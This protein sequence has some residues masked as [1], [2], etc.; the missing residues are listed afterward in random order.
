MTCLAG[1]TGISVT[2]LN[3]THLIFIYLLGTTGRYRHSTTF[4]FLFSSSRFGISRLTKITPECILLAPWLILA[5]ALA[6]AVNSVSQP[7]S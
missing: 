2:E 7:D 5:Q 3:S 1:K 4:A 6:I